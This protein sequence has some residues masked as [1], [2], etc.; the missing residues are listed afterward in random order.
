M[1]FNLPL[2][3]PILCLLLTTNLAHAETVA[4][5]SP[6]QLET[7]GPLALPLDSTNGLQ[8]ILQT[9]LGVIAPELQKI[10][11]DD[12]ALRAATNLV[13]A[14]N[15]V[16]QV[17]WGHAAPYLYSSVI[18]A[19][20][21]LFYSLSID[22]MRLSDGTALLQRGKL[23]PGTLRIRVIGSRERYTELSR[24]VSH[25]GQDGYWDPRTNEVGIFVDATIL[26]LARRLDDS[27][28]PAARLEAID[29][30]RSF[31]YQRIVYKVGHELFHAIQSNQS[32]DAYLFP[33][34]SEG[35]AMLAQDN[36]LTRE[37]AIVLIRGMQ[38]MSGGDQG[39]AATCDAEGIRAFNIYRLKRL[40][41]SYDA[42]MREPDFSVTALLAMDDGEFGAASGRDLLDRYAIAYAF[43]DILMSLDMDELRPYGAVIKELTA[44]AR[45]DRSRAEASK[46][47]K[48]F[49]D[50]LARTAQQ[51]WNSAEATAKFEAATKRVTACLRA[52]NLL[53]ALGSAA[54][55]FAYRSAS[56]TGPLY[57]G[58]I[59]YRLR[60]PLLALDFYLMAREAM[61]QPGS[62]D[63]PIRIQSRV[64]DAQELTGDVDAAIQTY[65]AITSRPPESPS[66]LELWVRATLKVEY[67]GRLQRRGILI[68]RKHVEQANILLNGF[69]AA[70]ENDPRYAT[71]INAN[72]LRAFETVVREK[73]LSTR[74]VMMQDAEETRP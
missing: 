15:L 20:G 16:D 2:R 60:Q 65:A 47:D 29:T 45:I 72:D 62:D 6:P 3:L 34:I 5:A 25:T 14:D 39:G 11:R 10:P 13:D 66:M 37:N 70:L 74:A 59:F 40:I 49:R 36:L 69:W 24:G 54:E 28:Q 38:A 21:R 53:N 19:L 4:P 57:A 71:A 67:Y 63:Y 17:G 27:E 61:S 58:D 64:A 73:A 56:P 7:F 68:R 8:L 52:G 33:L 48:L 41:R 22:L 51:L 43:L 26:N 42:I 35:T 12:P 50:R 46:V 55:A 44:S 9:D 23:A 32:N 31:L 1:T 18:D 30:L